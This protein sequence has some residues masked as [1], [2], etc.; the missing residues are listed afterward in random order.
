MNKD[1]L[2]NHIA[3]DEPELI[4]A[5][6]IEIESYDFDDSEQYYKERMENN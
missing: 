2:G 1:Y 6:L 3:E 5:E 4:E